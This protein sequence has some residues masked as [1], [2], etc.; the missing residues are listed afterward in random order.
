[1]TN[2]RHRAVTT[3]AKRSAHHLAD[4]HLL[5]P[6]L[7]RV[8]RQ[9]QQSQ[10][11]D[12]HGQ[13]REIRDDGMGPLLFPI[14]AVQMVIEKNNIRILTGFKPFP[15]SLNGLDARLGLTRRQ[16]HREKT[17]LVQVGGDGRSPRVRALRAKT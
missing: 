14:E 1:M 6:L 15:H 8:G 13:P 12:K 3:L 4:G 5:A 11:A 16:A 9:A 2:S 7:G 17:A 10:G